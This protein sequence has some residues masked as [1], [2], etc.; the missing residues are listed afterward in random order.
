MRS[1]QRD[2]AARAAI[3]DWI[4]AAHGDFLS[5]RALLIA[6]MIS[7]WIVLAA[8]MLVTALHWPQTLALF[9]LGA[10]HADF[11]LGPKR[12]QRWGELIPPALSFALLIF[13]TRKKAG[14]A[15]GE[16]DQ[17]KLS[18]TARSRF[19]KHHRKEKNREGRF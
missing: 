5:Y 14:A 3:G 18:R 13:L 4:G 2:R 11:S 8:S 10:E 16:K 17:G 9:G 12:P 15:G 19:N 6:I 7:A 1:G